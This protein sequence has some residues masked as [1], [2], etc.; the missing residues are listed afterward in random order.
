MLVTLMNENGINRM[1][2]L[3]NQVD[4][5]TYEF[6]KISSAIISDKVTEFCVVHQDIKTEN[7]DQLMGDTNSDF[8]EVKAGLHAVV[9]YG[10]GILKA[11]TPDEVKTFK[12]I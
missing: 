6:R 12:N 10:S 4:E 8:S 3:E 2:Y 7:L 1:V 11:L 9:D 5:R